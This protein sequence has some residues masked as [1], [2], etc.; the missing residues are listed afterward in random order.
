[1]YQLA[2]HGVGLCFEDVGRGAPPLVLIHELGCDHSSFMPQIEYFRQGHRVIAIDLRG[3]GKS[4]SPEQDYTVA[5]FA[6]DVAW[7]CYELGVYSPVVVGHGLGGMIAL[8]LAARWPDLPSAVVALNSLFFPSP[9]T[10]TPLRHFEESL[11]IP[12]SDDAL[13]SLM[14]GLIPP[15]EVPEHRDHLLETVSSVSTQTVALAWEGARAWDVAEAVGGCRVPFL[16]IDAGT[17]SVDLARLQQICPHVA[18]GRTPGSSHFRHLE[19][20]GQVN[21]LIDHFLGLGATGTLAGNP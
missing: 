21:T 3:H 2:R 15:T 18:V 19:T 14:E 8:E 7:L 6:S 4:G 5:G 16:Y 17:K 10:C 13:R 20:P 9:E 1:V 12:V 11:R